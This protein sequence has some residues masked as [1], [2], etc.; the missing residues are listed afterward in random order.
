MEEKMINKSHK[1]VITN[2]KVGSLTGIIDVI[3]FDV[4]EILL[5]AAADKAQEDVDAL[6]VRVTSTETR[7]DQNSERIGLMATREE[8]TETLGGY[9]TKEQ[10]DAALEVKSDAVTIA[11]N[12]ELTTQVNTVD[13]KLEEFKTDFNKRI[14]FSSETAIT[15]GSDKSAVTLEIDNEKG[16][17][18]KENN[19]A[20][21]T[22][23]GK[24]LLAETVMFRTVEGSSGDFGFFKLS[25]G[26]L[27]FTKVGG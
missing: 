10:T 12:K 4:A 1:V 21:G 16:V 24:A 15:I 2:R 27:K 7:I 25:D 13:G 9:Y 17:S 19:Q 18:F 6:A 5:E 11:L 26:S 3:S 14:E 22:W 20:F 8:V 23:N